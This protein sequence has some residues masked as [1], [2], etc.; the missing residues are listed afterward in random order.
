MVVIDRVI[1][2]Q[3]CC[4][5]CAVEMAVSCIDIAEVEDM[6]CPKCKGNPQVLREV[7]RI[8]EAL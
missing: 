2:P 5:N 3:A 1:V 4:V 6:L 7:Q 8:M